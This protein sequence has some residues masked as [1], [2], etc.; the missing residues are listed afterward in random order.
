MTDPDLLADAA[1][2]LEHWLDFRQRTTRVPGLVAALTAAGKPLLHKAYG[3]SELETATPMTADM[4]FPIA[5]HSKTFTAAVVLRLVEQD[6]LRLD[7]Q[8]H[9]WLPDLPAELRE[10]RLGELL[11]HSSGVSRDSSDSDF[12]QMFRDFPDREGLVEAAAAVLPRND[13]FKYSNIGFGL[14]GLVIE[15]ATGLSYDDAA[16]AQVLD[17]L[18]LPGT[19]T[20]TQGHRGPVGYTSQAGGATRAPLP[21]PAAGALDPATGYC[22]TAL[23]LCRFATALADDSLLSADTGRLMRHVVWPGENGDQDYCLGLMHTRIGD[24]DAYGHGGSYPGFQTSTRF[25]VEDR[26]TAVALTNAI[27]G[28]A[29]ELTKSMLSVVDL[30]LGCEPGPLDVATGRYSSLWGTVDLVRFGTSLFALDP[31]LADPVERRV[32]L[33]LQGNGSW[34]IKRSSGF[35]SPGEELELFGDSIRLAGGTMRREL[36]W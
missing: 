7:D 23:D 8:L 2:Y 28:P 33:E 11:S 26:L 18:G 21:V 1:R 32:E 17:V 6:V 9:R 22:S 16:R 36:S 4:V 31:E 13:R 3:L 5:S 15:A 24:R 27:D 25:L 10:V 19:S 30:A 12:W 29:S 35:G 20:R 14:A 34:I